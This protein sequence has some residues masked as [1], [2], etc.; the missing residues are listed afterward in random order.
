MQAGI[1]AAVVFVA[2]GQARTIAMH[3]TIDPAFAAELEATTAAG[4]EVYGYSCPITPDGIRLGQAI[5]VTADGKR[6]SV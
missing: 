6:G 4:L 1:R 5:T 3:T 2:Q